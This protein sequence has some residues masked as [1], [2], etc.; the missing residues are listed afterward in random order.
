MFLQQLKFFQEHLQ[1]SILLS[2]W[3]SLGAQT[4]TKVPKMDMLFVRKKKVIAFLY[5]LKQFNN[6]YKNI[7]I[8][9]SIADLYPD[10]G[11]LP[12]IDNRIVKSSILDDIAP[13]L[14]DEETAG[15]EDHPSVCLSSTTATPSKPIVVLESTGV[16]DPECTAIPGRCL[17]ASALRN[18]VPKLKK[19]PD[20]VISNK[21]EAINEY[22][23]PSLFPG[24][25]PT[26][27]PFGLGGFDDKTRIQKISFPQQLDY[28][29]DT[30]DRRFRY[31][32][33]FIFIALNII[34][35]RTAHLYTHFTVNKPNFLSVAEKLTKISSKTIISAAQH[36][37][38]ESKVSKLPKNEQEVMYMLK[39]V[40]T[41]SNH[42][43]GSTASKIRARN[44]L[45]SY[46]GALGVP[47]LF[48]T[49][50]PSA[51]NSPIFQVAFGDEVVDL[52]NRFPELLPSKERYIRLALDPVAAADFFQFSIKNVFQY[53]LGWDFDKHLS[54]DHGGI[55]GHLDA[56]FGTSEFT[57]RG[58]LH[59]HFQIWL[60]GGL[61]PGQIHK[62]LS[63]N[64]QYQKTFFDFFEN[65]ISTDIPDP[66]LQSLGSL[67]PAS[68]PRTER[69]PCP[70]EIPIPQ[71]ST[72]DEID[73]YHSLLESWD[74]L[75]V[76]EIQYCAEKLQK[77]KCRPV[78]H[79]YGHVNDCR[80]KFPKD[81][82][83]K[84]YY[85]E[86][87]QAIIFVCKDGNVNNYNKYLLVFCR[88][89]HDLKC[90]L[91]GRAAKAAMFYITDYITKMDVKTYQLL[92]LLSHA[93]LNFENEKKKDTSLHLSGKQLLHKC[94]SQFTK[95]QQIH[96]QQA[97]RYARQFGDTFSSHNTIPMLSGTLMHIVHNLYP[98]SI[99]NT[100]IQCE[101]ETEMERIPIT[102]DNEGNIIESN[103]VHNYLY[104]DNDLSNI[105]FYDFVRCFRVEK[106]KEIKNISQ[107][108]PRFVLQSPHRLNTT[109]VIIQFRNVSVNS[110]EK[111]LLP[112]IIGYNVPRSSVV[113]LYQRFMLAH[114]KPFS[115]SNR[116][117]VDGEDFISTFSAYDFNNYHKQLMNNWKKY[118]CVRIVGMLKD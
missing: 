114:F 59:G 76:S 101:D 56:F 68:D 61:N 43:P 15:I 55:L 100:T 27:F 108:L 51:A 25:F 104:R 39:Q 28:F 30:K 29:L 17:T 97:A 11:L 37:Q 7:N 102:T 96:A 86:D 71:N 115:V 54:S 85:D 72:Q 35:R 63:N 99:E 82:I 34:Q 24:M 80:F 42:V 84:A 74:E 89:N 75:F 106:R 53:L 52:T 87:E 22:D 113:D 67:D 3:Y 118:I 112:R 57:E 66:L 78:C 23:N 6:E 98:P 38:K 91:S 79:K 19:V 103:Q 44:E 10:H 20:L 116:L 21:Y 77:H 92:T 4:W 12:D 90:I 65:I 60:K 33:S 18:L 8:D 16:C 88:H 93:V 1:M 41:I 49:L 69:P 31:H 95:K 9:L 32:R 73:R 109:H 45:L 94:V 40:N 107:S 111:E 64:P 36:L 70:P 83:E 46:A 110:V 48:L 47:H 58:C 105:C 62:R 117:I 14:F 2:L 81:V 50:N 26:L 13:E 5:F